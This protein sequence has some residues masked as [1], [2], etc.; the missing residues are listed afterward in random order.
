MSTDKISVYEKPQDW[1]PWKEEFERKAVDSRIWP[2]IRLDNSLPWP[3]APVPPK[4]KDY[5]RKQ[6]RG[7]NATASSS[8]GMMEQIILITYR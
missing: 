8:G 6:H 4:I 5:P 7:A 3:P 1:V 2:Y